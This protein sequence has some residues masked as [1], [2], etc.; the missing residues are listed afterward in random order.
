MYKLTLQE[1]YNILACGTYL[2]CICKG[3][4]FQQCHLKEVNMRFTGIAYVVNL[5][6]YNQSIEVK[7]MK[8]ID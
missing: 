4:E 2:K 7:G 5:E 6:S 3:K 8:R 1:Q